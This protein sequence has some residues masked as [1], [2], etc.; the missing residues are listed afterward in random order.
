MTMPL[1]APGRV[2]PDHTQLPDTD[3]KP[4]ENDQ[5]PPQSMLLTD[6]LDPVLR[7][8]YPDG[9]YWIAQDCGIYWR[10]PEA[11]EPLIRGAVSPDWYCVLGVK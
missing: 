10:L 8:L 4:V 9:L 6:C 2:L 7:R 5:Q 3:G 1:S 11:P